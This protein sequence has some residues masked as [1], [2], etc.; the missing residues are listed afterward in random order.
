MNF[1]LKWQQ[2]V[3]S[4]NREKDKFEINKGFRYNQRMKQIV[5]AT[6]TIFLCFAC[7]SQ[8]KE[9]ARA[10]FYAADGSKLTAVFLLK[11]AVVEITLPDGQ[12]FR[13]PQAVSASGARYSDGTN[14]FW[15]HQGGGVF[16]HNDQELFNGTNR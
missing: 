7:T 10:D 16:T 8:K 4:L 5:F 9:T 6:L 1:A 15:E 2:E 3:L 11:E 12:K 14:T 13:L